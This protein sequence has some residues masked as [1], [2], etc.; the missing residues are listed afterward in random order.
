MVELITEITAHPDFFK[1]PIQIPIKNYC[2]IQVKSSKILTNLAI[3]RDYLLNDSFCRHFVDIPLPFGQ[4]SGCRC[5]IFF[6]LQ[7]HS[8]ILSFKNLDKF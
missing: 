2:D 5:C 3:K 8:I 6:E 1:F 4:K 7:L